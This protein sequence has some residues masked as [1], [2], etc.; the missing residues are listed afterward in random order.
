ME[1]VPGGVVPA[2]TQSATGHCRLDMSISNI[3]LSND[4]EDANPHTPWESLFLAYA[5]MVPILAGA[6]GS[7]LLHGEAAAVAVHLTVIWSGAVLCFLSGVRRGLSFRQKGGPL[8][9]QLLFMLWLFVLGVASLLSVWAI[10]SLLL[11]LAGYGTIAFYDPVSA[12][13]GEVPLYF[14]VLRP[15]QMLIPIFSLALMLAGLVA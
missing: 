1:P 2:I 15:V 3:R 7:L 8:A 12:R 9:S 11:Q 4:T 5:A 6:L 13:K 10:P 14:R